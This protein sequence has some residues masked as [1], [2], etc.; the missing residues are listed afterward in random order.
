MGWFNALP[1][2]APA[3]SVVC[4]G[5]LL[6]GVLLAEAGAR[7]PAAALRSWLVGIERPHAAL[8]VDRA[9]IAEFAAIRVEHRGRNDVGDLLIAAT[10]RA[11][12][13]T[14]ASRNKRHFTALSVPVFNSWTHAP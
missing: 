7:A 6:E 14:V 1:A 8:P 13:L 10:A 9:V 12:G 5:E 4:I 2:T 3:T 11:H